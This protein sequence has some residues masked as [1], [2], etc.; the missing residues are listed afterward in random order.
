[1]G[2]RKSILGAMASNYQ[3]KAT[4]AATQGMYKAMWGEEPPKRKKRVKIERS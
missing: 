2:R 4:N 1:M 3:R